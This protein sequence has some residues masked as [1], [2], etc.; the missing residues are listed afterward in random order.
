MTSLFQKK[1]ESLCE[2]AEKLFFPILL[3]WQFVLFVLFMWQSS[4]ICH[5]IGASVYWTIEQTII[6]W[7]LFCRGVKCFNPPRVLM[8]QKSLFAVHFLNYFL[9]CLIAF[10]VDHFQVGNNIALRML[11][12]YAIFSTF[13]YAILA[14]LLLSFYIN[15][16]YLAPRQTGIRNAFLVKYQ[17][18]KLKK[19][20]KTTRPQETTTQESVTTES[21]GSGS[22][23]EENSDCAICL[24]K[25]DSKKMVCQL[26]CNHYYHLNCIYQWLER[27]NSKKACPLCN[28]PNRLEQV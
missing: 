20:L 12:S 17:E 27:E 15:F 19:W 9:L 11:Q 14:I 26:Q 21:N 10:Q 13:Y 23:S 5:S 22:S 4:A 25:F 2:R 1:I 18:I 24:D 6:A 16:Q 7:Q 3:S 8:M 28:Q